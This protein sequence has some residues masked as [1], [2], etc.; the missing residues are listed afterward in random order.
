MKNKLIIRNAIRMLFFNLYM[1]L[2]GGVLKNMIFFQI[3]P[4]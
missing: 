4:L 3:M 1:Y 2:L